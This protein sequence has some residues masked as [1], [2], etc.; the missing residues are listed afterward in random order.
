MDS[1]P[2]S[3]IESAK[4]TKVFVTDQL[5][6]YIINKTVDE[7]KAYLK[8]K[9]YGGK[10]KCGARGVLD[11]GC[12]KETVGHTC[13]RV[14]E[15]FWNVLHARHEMKKMANST[16][17]PLKDIWSN[18]LSHSTKRVQETINFPQIQSSMKY[19]R[20]LS[21]PPIPQSVQ[22]TVEVLESGEHPFGHIYR[23][24]VSFEAEKGKEKEIGL[25]FAAN[26]CLD[27]LPGIFISFLSNTF[28]TYFFN[29]LLPHVANGEWQQDWIVNFL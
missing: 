29:C 23:G 12:L 26:E 21:L 6:G 7:N 19:Q 3:V 15:E 11:F 24:W 25:I 13:E 10:S 28:L 22:K 18:V 2:Y 1:V 17:V 27:I 20:S 4:F 8:C 14:D 9:F 16:T 5:R